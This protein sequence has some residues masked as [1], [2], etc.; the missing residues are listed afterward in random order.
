MSRRPEA[1]GR[2]PGGAGFARRSPLGTVPASLA[3]QALHASV[4]GARTPVFRAVDQSLPRAIK[5]QEE[6]HVRPRP[7][8]G[9][10]NGAG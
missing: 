10:P 6:P 2:G 5:R 4:P 3:C 9:E 8:A 7:E 1:R